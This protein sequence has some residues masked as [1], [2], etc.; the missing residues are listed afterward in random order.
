[1]NSSACRV[2]VA[3]PLADAPLVR[4]VHARLRQHGFLPVS[5]WAE[6][7]S[8]YG[9]DDFEDLAA[10]RAKMALNDAG[11]A[12]A[13]VFLVL[14]RD[15]AGGEMF[16]E[17]RMAIAMGAPVVWVGR[18]VLSTFREGVYHFD[19]LELAM[20]FL[21][22]WGETMQQEYRRLRDADEDAAQ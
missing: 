18:R 22:M 17:A 21:L 5:Y 11:V 16:C 6:E 12:G 13:D 10:V 3:A 15:G 19:G 9:V 14:A 20:Q 2:Y 8:N 7:P 1:M 4:D